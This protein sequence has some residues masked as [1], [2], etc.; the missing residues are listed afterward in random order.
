MADGSPPSRKR[1]RSPTRSTASYACD[2][3][4]SG[5]GKPS[6]KESSRLADCPPSLVQPEDVFREPGEDEEPGFTQ[7][8]TR[9]PKTRKKTPVKWRRESTLALVEKHVPSKIVV[10]GVPWQR[11]G[12][13]YKKEKAAILRKFDDRKLPEQVEARKAAKRR[14]LNLP[15]EHPEEPL[16]VSVPGSHSDEEARFGGARA[17]PEDAAPEDAAPEEGAPEEGAAPHGGAAVPVAVAV[18]EVSDGEA[19]YDSPTTDP[20]SGSD[21]ENGLFG[22]FGLTHE[23]TP[24]P[25]AEPPS[26]PPSKEDS[27]E[28]DLYGF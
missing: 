3:P 8:Q 25:V 15:L 6:A 28:E 14:R 27:E 13:K 23:A 17:A 16:E 7:N 24:A 10:G 1:G 22:L 21:S 2:N 9:T 19:M 11:G 12:G 4:N 20:G 5:D 26:E 18:E